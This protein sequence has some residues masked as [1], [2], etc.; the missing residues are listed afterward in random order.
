M[1]VRNRVAPLLA[2]LTHKVVIIALVAAIAMV[3]GAMSVGTLVR[4]R[5]LPFA[6]PLAGSSAPDPVRKASAKNKPNN[7]VV[8]GSETDASG[9]KQSTN[10]QIIT[11]AASNHGGAVI[12]EARGSNAL[13][14]AGNA[15]AAPPADVPGPRPPVTLPTTPATSPGQPI[16]TPQPP[17]PLLPLRQVTDTVQ[18]ILPSGSL[19]LNIGI[20]L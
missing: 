7:G 17:A 6:I 14:G 9:S 13:S 16:T 11:N 8:A 15:G 19:Q 1:S 3:I 20:G 18:G 5:H 2:L 4:H 12:G 10:G